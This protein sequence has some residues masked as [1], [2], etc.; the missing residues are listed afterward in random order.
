MWWRVGGDGEGG[1]GEG[2]GVEK[3]GAPEVLRLL[4]L[5]L[6]M[7]IMAM[8]VLGAMLLL[9]EPVMCGCL[10]C[11]LR[12]GHQLCWGW[13][14]RWGVL[15]VLDSPLPENTG[16]PSRGTGSSSVQNRC[17]ICVFRDAHLD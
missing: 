4:L 13:M 11:R 16:R 6:M 14:L 10:L 3:G 7:T 2:E 1:L 17:H 12:L 5:L 9:S 15:G 8:K